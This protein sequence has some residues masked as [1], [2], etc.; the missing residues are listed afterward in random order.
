MMDK[1][2]TQKQKD[3][4]KYYARHAEKIK[5]QKKAQ[6]REND[7]K[8]GKKKP[9]RVKHPKSHKPKNVQQVLVVNPRRKAWEQTNPEK[10]RITEETRKQLAIR[11]KIEDIHLARELGIDEF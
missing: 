3:N 1:P 10:Y 5:A 9:Q 4:R 6:K 7:Q 8:D 2:L 11:R